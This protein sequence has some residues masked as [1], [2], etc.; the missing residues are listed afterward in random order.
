MAPAVLAPDSRNRALEHPSRTRIVRLFGNALNAV[1]ERGWTVALAVYVVLVLATWVPFGFRIAGLQEEWDILG[2]LDRGENLWWITADSAAASHRLRPLEFVPHV[3][4]YKL[5]GGFLWFNIITVAA[6]VLKGLAVFLLVE[7][8]FPGRRSVALFA[9]SLALFHPA[10]TALFTFRFLPGYVAI[11]LFLFALVFLCDLARRGGWWRAVAAI[12]L[13]AASLLMYQIA[14]AATLLGPVMLFLVG[15]RRRRTLALLSA[16]WF[17]APVA[18]AVRG[19]PIWRHGDVYE[20]RNYAGQRPTLQDYFFDLKHG[21]RWQLLDAWRPNQW[22]DW[23]PRYL[24]L[25]VASGAIVSIAVLATRHA[26]SFVVAIALVLGFAVRRAAVLALVAAG[27]TSIAVTYGLHQ[28][29]HYVR[30]TDVRLRVLGELSQQLPSPRDG[31]MIVIRDRTAHLFRTW[32]PLSTFADAVMVAYRNPTLIVVGCDIPH[33]T[34]Y[35]IGPEQTLAICP[36][37]RDGTDIRF[38][39]GW[40]YPVPPS[41]VA[42]FDYTFAD[43]LRLVR[44]IS[45]LP[46]YD[47][48]ALADQGR[49]S[50]AGSLFPCDPIQRCTPNPTAGWPAGQVHEVLDAAATNLIGFRGV[51]TS[52]QGLPFQWTDVRQA[53]VFA[54]L[55]PRRSRFEMVVLFALDP[56]VLSSVRVRVN[57]VRLPATIASRG[58]GAIVSAVIPASALRGTLDDIEISSDVVR[59]APGSDERLGLMVHR[60]DITPVGV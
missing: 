56:R 2:M 44:R 27:L 5:G 40:T 53:H 29:A 54:R 16:L 20:K 3:M 60:I 23:N 22:V 41:L 30:Q 28:H 38:W 48:R 25:G 37:G 17:A 46:T 51:E 42:V 50:R 12:G 6:F 14:F 32:G 57:G 55:P 8:L 45:R 4:A 35:L 9:G 49:V 39:T 19:I 36:D 24:A 58:G 13:L 34:T 26:S 33:G 10:N 52:A 1:S 47:P 11:V 43:E 7:R 21:Y 15:V 59:A 31:T 18:V